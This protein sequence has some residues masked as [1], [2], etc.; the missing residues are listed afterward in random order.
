MKKITTMIVFAFIL[1]RV[2]AQNT[3]TITVENVNSD[4]AIQ[5]IENAA[6][7]LNYTLDK[8]DKNNKVLITDF[9]EWTS[10]AIQNHAKLKFEALDNKVVISMIERQYSSTDGWVNSPTNLSKKNINKYLGAFADKII[11]INASTE[12]L[13]FAVENSILIPAFKSTTTVLGVEWKL[14]SIYQKVLS[15]KKEL[16]LCFTLTNTNSYPVDLDV[17]LWNPKYIFLDV[18][19]EMEN[20]KAIG[21]VGNVSFRPHLNAGEKVSAIFYYSSTNIITKIPKYYLR[22]Y[23]NNGTNNELGKLTIYNIIV[24]YYSEL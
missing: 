21:K 14:D 3:A 24:P 19:A 22:H 6:K 11:Q 13:A 23:V 4:Q 8:Y 7:D 18:E 15:Q 5:I 1:F 10:I 16:I 17:S 9:F 2:N 12:M 20:M